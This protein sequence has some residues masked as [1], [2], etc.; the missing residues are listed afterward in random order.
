MPKYLCLKYIAYLF[1]VTHIFN[2]NFTNSQTNDCQFTSYDFVNR[3]GGDCNHYCN[4][5][6]SNNITTKTLNIKK[7]L[8]ATGKVCLPITTK[9]D[10][11]NPLLNPEESLNILRATIELPNN[12]NFMPIASVNTLGQ[13]ANFSTSYIF[14]NQPKILYGSGFDDL[15]LITF[16]IEDLAESDINAF[17]NIAGIDTLLINFRFSVKFSNQNIYSKPPTVLSSINIDRG[18]NLTDMFSYVNNIDAA[19]LN[20]FEVIIS[21]VTTAGFNINI[22]T[23]FT[24]NPFIQSENT[25]YK[26]ESIN[27]VIAQLASQSIQIFI[28]VIG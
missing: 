21:N 5:K 24:V 20:G 17:S 8:Q 15:S 9:I 16:S 13:A 10:C 11:K 2:N 25:N 6:I 12:L 23:S 4:L 3:R 28:E 27:N 22:L 18:I 1:I 14:N 26:L 7:K 19:V